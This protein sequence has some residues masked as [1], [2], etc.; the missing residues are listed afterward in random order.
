MSIALHP[1]ICGQPFRLRPLRQALRHCVEH[2]RR[3]EV[4]FT[5]AGQLAEYC[6]TLSV[7]KSSEDKEVDD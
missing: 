7:Y 5:C 3:D 6:A 1:F 4:W 2:K